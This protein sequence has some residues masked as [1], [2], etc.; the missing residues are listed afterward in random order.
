LT[1]GG[2]TP[3]NSD[4]VNGTDFYTSNGVTE[5][6]ETKN[7]SSQVNN[8]YGTEKVFW[9]GV[10]SADSQPTTFL[11]GADSSYTPAVSYTTASV[12]LQPTS[13]PVGYTAEGYNLYGISLQANSSNYIVIS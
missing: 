8:T 4:I 6:S 9:F 1:N 5:L 12:N 13:P 11:M 7:F 10:R 2:V 3:T